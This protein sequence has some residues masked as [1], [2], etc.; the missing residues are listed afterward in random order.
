MCYPCA[1]S[2]CYQCARSVPMTVIPAKAGISVPLPCAGTIGDHRE[3]NPTPPLQML[4]RGPGGEARNFPPPRPLSS[5]TL[6]Q[7]GLALGCG[8]CKTILEHRAP[9]G[10]KVHVSS[11]QLTTVAPPPSRGHRVM[12][13]P[14]PRHPT[15][16]GMAVRAPPRGHRVLTYPR[17]L[18][19][20]RRVSTVRV[21]RNGRPITSDLAPRQWRRVLTYPWP[22]WSGRRVSTVC[23]PRR[24]PP[25]PRR[26]AKPGCARRACLAPLPLPT[27]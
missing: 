19:P 22:L 13:D 27:P 11:C 20:G 21:P 6:P 16:R 26:P 1:R 7:Y 2:T 10:R 8:R 12:S 5:P 25:C 17:P 18:R 3:A 15:W 4:E 9:P 24:T 14:A 23:V